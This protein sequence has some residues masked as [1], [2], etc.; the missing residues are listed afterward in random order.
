MN[1]YI[2]KDWER[3]PGANTFLYYSFD[4][5][6]LN[7]DS[8]NNRNW[9]WYSWAWSYTTWI[10]WYWA[11]NWDRWIKM[12]SFPTWDFTLSF[13]VKPT[14]NS[15]SIQTM[16]WSYDWSS[17]WWY[18]HIHMYNNSYSWISV[19]FSNDGT[20]NASESI[21]RWDWNHIVF[22]R[23]WSTC[24]LYKNKTLILTH[25]YSSALVANANWL[26]WNW[27]NT[28]RHVT[29]IFDE[30]IVETRW[31]TQE[32]ID[33]YYDNIKSLYWIS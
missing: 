1:V 4:N 10:K 26:I 25:T 19:W 18:I 27:Y 21:T 33:N 20:Y 24:K 11:N 13:W 8:W 22:T 17:S 31:W 9:T 30:I 3:E 2:Y 32:E 12:P 16:F 14:N 28:D 23:S 7:D 29:W 5:Q 15:L 6:N